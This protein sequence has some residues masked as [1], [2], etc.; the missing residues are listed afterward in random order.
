MSATTEISP[1]KKLA[2]SIGNLSLKILRVDIVL[3]AIFALLKY[4]DNLDWSW[5]RVA[6][7]IWLWPAQAVGVVVGLFIAAGIWVGVTEAVKAV[8]K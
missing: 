8:R 3:T 1:N 6:M 2:K 4:T 5:T 7:P